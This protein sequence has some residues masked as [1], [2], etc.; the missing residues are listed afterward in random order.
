[1]DGKG[2]YLDNIF[3][4]RLWRSVKYEG[5]YL[6]AYDTV[7]EAKKRIG[8]YIKFYNERRFHQ[9]L[10]YQTPT[11]FHDGEFDDG[12]GGAVEFDFVVHAAVSARGAV[13]LREIDRG[14]DAREKWRSAPVWTA[15][16]RDGTRPQ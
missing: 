8:A 14:G 3:I 10:G 2:R 16:E 15:P 12:A 1:M 13:E 11:A 5:V 7:G 9:A 4:E 6:H